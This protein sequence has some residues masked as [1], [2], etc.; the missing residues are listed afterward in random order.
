MNKQ[1]AYLPPLS[2]TDQIRKCAPPTQA[3]II[4]E[5]RGSRRWILVW[6]SCIPRT[7]TPKKSHDRNNVTIIVI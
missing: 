2:A 7:R 6:R 1:M 5:K 4:P 3:L